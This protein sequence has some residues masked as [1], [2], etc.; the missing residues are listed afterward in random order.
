MVRAGLRGVVVTDKRGDDAD[1]TD[2]NA[3]DPAA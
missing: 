1:K 2:E 3:P